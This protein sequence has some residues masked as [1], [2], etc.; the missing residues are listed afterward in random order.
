MATVDDIPFLMK[1]NTVNP[2]L[3]SIDEFKAILTSHN[4]YIIVAEKKGKKGK[5]HVV[6]FIHYSLV[7]HIPSR[8][9]SLVSLSS[10][11]KSM[12]DSDSSSS[13]QQT[14][15]L[16]K[17]ELVHSTECGVLD[18]TSTHRVDNQR[19]KQ[20]E[21]KPK[22]RMILRS[23]RYAHQSS[24]SSSSHQQT[25]HTKEII[26]VE[27]EEDDDDENEEEE[28]EDENEESNTY[29]TPT[30]SRKYG[31]RLTTDDFQSIPPQRVGYVFA[32]QTVNMTTHCK[33]CQKHTKPEDYTTTI[34]F[35]IACQHAKEMGMEYLLC[36]V[37]ENT[38][39]YFTHLFGMQANPRGTNDRV[40]L[41]LQLSKFTYHQFINRSLCM[42]YLPCF[43]FS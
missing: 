24:S 31:D 37:P 19:Q 11:Q 15:H 18:C 39:G 30:H 21:E 32:V 7:Y 36:D 34:L 8:Q 38:V 5:P 42:I 13:S 3:N 20:S 25:S 35:S 2:E 4:E 33:Y 27:E 40:P 17:N 14:K 29:T 43:S 16:K 1:I 28:E 23:G 12:T 9:L 10:S 41:Q 22:M 26:D 6:G